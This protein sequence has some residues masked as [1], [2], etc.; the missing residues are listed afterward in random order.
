MAISSAP[1]SD[2]DGRI[3]GTLSV[4]IDMSELIEGRREVEEKG[5]NIA[6]AAGAAVNSAGNV[7][8]QLA[9]EVERA[10]K[11]AELQSVRVAETS[12][13]MTEMNSAM[14]AVA[15]SAS[16][17]AGTT[18]RA[19]A[20]PRRARELYAMWLR[21]SAVWPAMPKPCGKA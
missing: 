12:S 21:V 16:Q 6:E 2:K 17:A 5:R 10:A 18:D 9:R 13:A 1:F 11:G 19:R 20:P 8:T 7:P 14:L 3:L 15:R 4:W